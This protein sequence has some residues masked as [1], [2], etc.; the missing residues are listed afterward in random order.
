MKG[1]KGFL[2]RKNY[3]I[4]DYKDCQIKVI[5]AKTFYEIQLRRNTELLY[6]N[7]CKKKELS[8]ELDMLYKIL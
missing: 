3:S 8:K 6:K 7:S 1:M 2:N 4:G 5:D